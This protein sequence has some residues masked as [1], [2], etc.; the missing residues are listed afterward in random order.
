MR[1]WLWFIVLFSSVSSVFSQERKGSEFV[2]VNADVGVVVKEEVNGEQI[3][4]YVGLQYKERK[5][6]T[7][8]D[9]HLKYYEG[10]GIYKSSSFE[11]D[12]PRLEKA[13]VGEDKIYL[14]VFIERALWLYSFGFDGEQLTREKLMYMLPGSVEN[15]GGVKFNVYN[16][17]YGEAY[18]LIIS[19]RRVVGRESKLFKLNKKDSSVSE[20]LFNEADEAIRTCYIDEFG[21][22]LFNQVQ[23]KSKI[24]MLIRE[25]INKK[26]FFVKM[27]PID[28][29]EYASME[30]KFRALNIVNYSVFL[31]D[32][33][34]NI[35]LIEKKAQEYLSELLSTNISKPKVLRESKLGGEWYFFIQIEGQLKIVRYNTFRSEWIFSDYSELPF[36]I[37]AKSKRMWGGFNLEE[38]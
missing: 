27:P 36:D 28:S 35:E 34:D 20:V 12:M 15:F 33:R 2:Q 8:I 5:E 31:Y 26:Y 9:V 6:T 37:D 38:E 14:F 18:Y 30:A 13:I 32:E 10:I 4:W 11:L 1:K 25:N 16:L 23:D 24:D 29:P 19:H 21:V 3:N 7:L 17:E 22:A